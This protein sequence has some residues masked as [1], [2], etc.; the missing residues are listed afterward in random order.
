MRRL[1]AAAFFLSFCAPAFAALP[2]R[3]PEDLARAAECIITGEVLAS[4]VLIHRK[5]SSSL[6]LVRLSAAIQSVEKGADLLDDPK[7]IEI[8]CWRMRRSNLV[9]PSGHLSIPA[10]G[11][12]FKM[13]LRKNKDG[14]WEP[15]EPNGIELQEGA[16]EM[17]FAETEK[18]HAIKQFF[19]GGGLG[20]LA[21]IAFV[22]Y[23]VRKLRPLRLDQ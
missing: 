3:S 13:W 2:P 19:I 5:P 10:D 14:Q 15:L 11:A 21:L 12:G 4:R 18:S 6:Y 16:L 17:T 1:L 9:G 20:L 23:R 22:I 7:I 8:R